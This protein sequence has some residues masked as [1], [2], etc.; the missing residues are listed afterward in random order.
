MRLDL[1]N[2]D[3]LIWFTDPYIMGS[4]L[5]R[6]NKAVKKVFLELQILEVRKSIILFIYFFKEKN[7]QML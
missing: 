1:T 7:Y 4:T 5:S 2:N 6:M 3:L